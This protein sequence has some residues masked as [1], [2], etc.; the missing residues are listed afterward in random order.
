MNKLRGF[1]SWNG[2]NYG[3]RKTRSGNKFYKSKTVHFD[4]TL[5]NAQEIT[6]DEYFEKAGKYAKVVLGR[7]L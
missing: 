3:Y 2:Y 7:D 4:G 5:E 6:A 1:I